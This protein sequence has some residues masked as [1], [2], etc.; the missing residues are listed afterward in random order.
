MKKK[1]LGSIIFIFILFSVIFISIGV[2]S[3]Q[4]ITDEQEI[5][6]TV[7]GALKIYEKIVFPPQYTKSPDIPIP[8]D[9]VNK[10][11][12]EVTDE[13]YK[14]FSS[15]SG[16]L[17]NRIEVFKNAVFFEAY[18]NGGIRTVKDRITDIKFLEINIEGDTAKVVADV[19]EE[20]KAVLS[21]LDES[22]ISS[23]DLE[24]LNNLN[25]Y[26]NKE[27]LVKKKKKEIEELVKKLPKK[28]DIVDRSG[29]IRYYYN[30]IKENGKW[31]IISENLTFISSNNMQ[32]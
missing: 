4:N 5:K 25:V 16:W 23:V 21:V 7:I 2:R 14:S 9:V 28:T 32:N 18:T 20:N 26:G 11:V 10:K 17:D 3:S 15:K 29:I 24:K 6:N 30:L 31:K 8:P 12:K 1:V 22:K 19:Y 27:D 13:C